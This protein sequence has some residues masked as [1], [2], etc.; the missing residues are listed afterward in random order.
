MLRGADITVVAKT[1]AAY[2]VARTRPGSAAFD[3]ARIDGLGL[4][5]GQGEG[6]GGIQL[7]ANV[8][9]MQ[10]TNNVLEN[11]GGVFAGGIGLG[12]PYAHGSHNFNVR[13]A[14]DRLHRQRRP[15]PLRRP[16]DLLRLEQ[17]RGRAAT[18]SA[19]TSASTTAPASRHSGLSPGGTIH[20]NQIYYNDAVDSG[21]GIAIETEIAGGRR[22]SATAP[23]RSTS[24]AT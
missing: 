20:D 21:A 14:N 13:I 9:N 11:N 10:L 23:A 7:Q 24:T 3:G 4:M 15:D 19:R 18:S 5:T 8:N 22:R 12:Q 2:N 17:L 16:R 1:T 6:A